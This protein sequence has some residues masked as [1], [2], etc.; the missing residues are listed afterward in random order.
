MIGGV[1]A[2]M[3][4]AAK[5]KRENP[6]LEVIVFE[7]SGYISYGACGMPYVVGGLIA[8]VEDL[9]A[10]TPQQM[11]E[12]GVEVRLQHE[13][14]AIDPE[15]KSVTVRDLK[16][17]RTF[18]QGYDK[19]VIATG[20]SPI[21]PKVEGVELAGVHVMRTLEDTEAILK[22]LAAGVKRAVIVGGGYIGL[23]LAE[24]LRQREVKVTLIEQQ[25]KLLI[26]FGQA[27]SQHVL[28]V[29]EQQGVRVKLG[30]VLTGLKGQQRV[31]TVA[32][33]TGDLRADMVILAVGAR[34]N[35]GL[36]QRIGAALGPQG[37]ILTDPLLQTSVPEIYAAGD[38][39]AV[40]HR[41]SKAPVWLPLGDTANRQGRALGSL[42]A[43]KPARF[44]GVLGSAV[45]KVFEAA[46]A[47]T[48]LNEEAARAAGFA[49][50]SNTVETTDHA[51]YYPDAAPLTVTLVWDK[52]SGR[53]LG[54]Q[55]VGKGDAVKRIDVIAALLSKE[56]TLHD[57]AALD[58]AYAPPFSGV[59]DA[60][61]LA[62]N[63]ALGL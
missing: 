17:A 25:K 34:P 31:S 7:K 3:S 40:M 52:T 23:E 54:A 28:E 63:V 10:R 62:A 19:L 42:L 41:V 1:A 2:G 8:G 12:Q 51:G 20:A 36:A 32:T 57:L 14:I 24:N 4:A 29:L 39:T 48:G 47:T 59:W 60:L 49:A 50:T 30:T 45:V 53:L 27:A 16:A 9:L 18:T 26:P 58:L 46:Y 33:S 44:S 21:I 35:S 6:K 5:A 61:L 22:T 13:V 11:A 55:L 56:A 38:V 37:A 43:G 15:A